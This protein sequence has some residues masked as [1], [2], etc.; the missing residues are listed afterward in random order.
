MIILDYSTPNILCYFNLLIVLILISVSIFKRRDNK[1]LTYSIIINLLCLLFLTII[2]WLVTNNQFSNFPHVFF[3]MPI[4]TGLITIAI[5]IYVNVSL[6]GGRFK[7]HNLLFFI[8]VSA[9]I[10][11]HLVF[12]FKSAEEKKA[13]LYC[14]I[15]GLKAN[16]LESGWL[17]TNDFHVITNV[18]ITFFIAI[19]ILIKLQKST[20]KIAFDRFNIITLKNWLFS[21][22]AY[23]LIVS[24]LIYIISY[25]APNPIYVTLEILLTTVNLIVIAFLIKFDNYPN[26]A[27]NEKNGYLNAE[28]KSGI[29]S[30]Q[31]S[32]IVEI[33]SKFTSLKKLTLDKKEDNHLSNEEEKKFKELDETILNYFKITKSFILNDYKVKSLSTDVRIPVYIITKWLNQYKKI[34]FTE[35]MNKLRIDEMLSRIEEEDLLEKFTIVAISNM[36]GFTN[37]TTFNNAFKVYIGQTPSQYFKNKNKTFREE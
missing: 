2:G 31:H 13:Y 12:Y 34:R 26:I 32:A 7:K 24:E 17:F 4:A 22:W 27:V 37:R 23:L 28:H 14:Q 25:I 18:F 6:N 29:T 10:L 33:P 21:L 9:Y 11:D 5:F 36:V 30:A 19:L 1:Y 16:Q 3:T 20:K 8:P 15:D 35:L